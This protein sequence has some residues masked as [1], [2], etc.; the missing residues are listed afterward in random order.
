MKNKKII[1]LVIVGMMY[2]AD[3]YADAKLP[4][5]KLMALGYSKREISQ[6]EEKPFMLKVFQAEQKYIAAGYNQ[7]EAKRFAENLEGKLKKEYAGYENGFDTQSNP[8]PNNRMVYNI[9]K[10]EKSYSHIINVASEHYNVPTS[11]IKAIIKTESNFNNLA[12]SKRGARGLTQLMPKTAQKMG[13]RNSH[14][15]VQNIYG[16][17]RYMAYLL[18]MFRNTDLALAAYNA[19]EKRVIDAGGI[20]NIKETKDF[21]TTVKRYKM[22]YEKII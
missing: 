13:V 20:P 4:A 5:D 1:P 2:F 15:P 14:D 8:H 22:M 18:K 3:V 9:T 16:G 17:V 11:L 7:T 12:V 21:V 10:N 6:I 19:G